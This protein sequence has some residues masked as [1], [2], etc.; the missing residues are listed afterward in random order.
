MF[1][2]FIAIQL[3]STME[4]ARLFHHLHK[5]YSMFQEGVWSIMVGHYNDLIS[6]FVSFISECIYRLVF[7]LVKYRYRLQNP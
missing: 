7:P 6:R 5:K 3:W 4:E 1:S 2:Q